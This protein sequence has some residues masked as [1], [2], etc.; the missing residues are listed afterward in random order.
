[1]YLA[2]VSDL[3][4][5][6]VVARA[7]TGRTR[8]VDARQ[9]Q[10]LDADESLTLAGL[11]AALRDVEGEA[12]GIVARARASGRG[13]QLADVVEEAGI[14]CEVRAR[15]AADRL[16]IDPHQAV[17]LV[18]SARDPAAGGLGRRVLERHV[19][20]GSPGAAC[21]SCGD[22]LDEDL[23]HQARLAGARNAGHAW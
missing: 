2:A 22:E 8:R 23:A 7:V 4:R 20:V 1:M 21:P 12:P 16:L 17:D 14:G 11:A 5:L 6:R 15:R 3:E 9:E 13:E 19:L 10:Q 18:Q